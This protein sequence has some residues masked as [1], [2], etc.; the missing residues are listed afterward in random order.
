MPTGRFRIGA[1]RFRVSEQYGAAQVVGQN[2]GTRRMTKEA[3]ASVRP[4]LSNGQR[5]AWLGSHRMILKGIVLYVGYS[6]PLSQ[7]P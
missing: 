2:G 7:S 5:H 4:R 1:D 3:V 6:R